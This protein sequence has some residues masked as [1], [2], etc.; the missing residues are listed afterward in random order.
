MDRARL[1]LTRIQP[2]GQQRH[3]AMKRVAP[4]RWY[5]LWQEAERLL[6]QSRFEVE[7]PQ[8]RQSVGTSRAWVPFLDEAGLGVERGVELEEPRPR[9]GTLLEVLHVSQASAGRL[10]FCASGEQLGN[11]THLIAVTT[12]QAAL[13]LRVVPIDE[14][15]ADVADREPKQA[16]QL[17]PHRLPLLHG[18]RQHLLPAQLAQSELPRPVLDRVVE[19]LQRVASAP[20]VGL[21]LHKDFPS[22]G[23]AQPSPLAQGTRDEREDAAH[24]AGQYPRELAARADAHLKVLRGEVLDGPVAPFVAVDHPARHSA[25]DLVQREG[26]HR[27]R[28]REARDIH[29]R[30]DS[31][32]LRG[33]QCGCHGAVSVVGVEGRGVVPLESRECVSLDVGALVL[34]REVDS[35]V[36]FREVGHGHP[37]SHSGSMRERRVRCDCERGKRWGWERGWALTRD[38]HN[39]RDIEESPVDPRVIREADDGTVIERLSHV[40]RSSGEHVNE[41]CRVL[42]KKAAEDAEDCIAGEEDKIAVFEPEVG[43]ASEC[44]LAC[45]WIVQFSGGDDH[46][47]SRT[48]G[49]STALCG[50]R[51]LGHS[52]IVRGKQEREGSVTRAGGVAHA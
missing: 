7:V 13:L 27:E 42:Y 20:R 44:L 49:A 10:R 40:W 50:A 45:C 32:A 19:G 25:A 2:L 52:V 31:A 30:N 26:E 3:P 29:G 38:A 8:S 41:Y 28:V 35:G 22:R 14:S 16:R 43:M 36:E 15:T 34:V 1:T 23:R 39:A 51:V 5:P 47:V 18:A 48:E 37:T 24:E 33:E 12:I 46:K 11:N 17:L 4:G 6:F 21:R 9:T